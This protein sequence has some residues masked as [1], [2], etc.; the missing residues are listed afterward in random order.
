MAEEEKTKEE[1]GETGST[2]EEPKPSSEV[3]PS[4]EL[5]L[6]RFKTQDDL[7]KAYKE[8]ETEF[9]KKGQD[10]VTVQKQLEQFQNK[11]TEEIKP[12]PTETFW[13]D[14]LKAVGGLIDS[15]LGP[16]HD[17]LIES[18]KVNLRANKDFAK[19]EPEIDQILTN[20]PQVKM[21]PNVV[22]NLYKMVKYGLHTEDAEKELREKIKSEMLTKGASVVEGASTSEEAEEGTK[23][24]GEQKIIAH[25]MFPDLP[26][27]Q[28][29]QKY[30]E[31]M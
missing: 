4:S 27:A 3:K 2:K 16:V 28:A 30:I 11:P 26:K 29:E 23:L 21:Q 8:L 14:P 31:G 12:D 1:L 19:Y 10:L 24:T 13:E 5:I 18:Q 20:F 7:E 9:T 6:G 15:K 25:K 17:I 22:A